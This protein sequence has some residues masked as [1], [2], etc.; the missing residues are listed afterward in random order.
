MLEIRISFAL[1]KLVLYAEETGNVLLGV[2]GL[3]KGVGREQ[4]RVDS[5]S[6]TSCIP[7]S[8]GT[9][10]KKLFMAG[11]EILKMCEGRELAVV[12]NSKSQCGMSRTLFA[13][14]MTPIWLLTWSSPFAGSIEAG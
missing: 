13:S 1:C 14:L 3:E 12:A 4:V 9:V 5:A 8:S 10:W 11:A 7:M 2:E 6:I